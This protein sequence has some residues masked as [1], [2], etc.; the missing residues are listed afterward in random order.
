MN[1]N[2]LETGYN[3][4]PDKYSARTINDILD[5]AQYTD[6]LDFNGFWLSEHYDSEYSWIGSPEILIPILLG[7]T[8][9]ISVGTGSI[10][11]KYH[12][13]LRIAQ[14][15]K[16]LSALFPGRIDLGI[17]ASDVPQEFISYLKGNNYPHNVNFTE[18]A[19]ELYAIINNEKQ[20]KDQIRLQPINTSP[21]RMWIMGNSENSIKTAVKIKANLCLSLY[22]GFKEINDITQIIKNFKNS[23]YLQNNYEPEVSILYGVLASDDCKFCSKLEKHYSKSL[24]NLIIGSQEDCVDRI[25]SLNKVIGNNSVTITVLSG[26]S[27]LKKETLS[28]KKE[29]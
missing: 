14:S 20:F 10:L 19:E 7:I 26:K 12:S 21:P 6:K 16:L 11:L 23:F 24:H 8:K 15:F 28:I 29:F 5:I 2:Y 4:N 22:H 27:E 17:A 3:G 25:K 13:P 1:F 18:V 9:N